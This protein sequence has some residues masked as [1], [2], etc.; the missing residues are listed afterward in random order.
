MLFFEQLLDSVPRNKHG[1]E[2]SSG[3]EAVLGVVFEFESSHQKKERESQS[4]PPCLLVS[5]GAGC[6]VSEANGE[7][8]LEGVGATGE[9]LFYTEWLLARGL[10]A[11]ETLQGTRNSRATRL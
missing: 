1:R 9:V 10:C 5:S 4:G 8:A 11:R 7:R 6:W 2:E 3:R